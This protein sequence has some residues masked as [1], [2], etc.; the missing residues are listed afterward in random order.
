MDSKKGITSEEINFVE[1]LRKLR[2]KEGDEGEHDNNN[3]NQKKKK[4]ILVANKCE[5]L[6]EH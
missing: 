4:V 3:R 2:V 6:E 5:G 1:Y